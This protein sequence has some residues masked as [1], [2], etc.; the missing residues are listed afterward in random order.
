MVTFAP[1]LS[2]RY[3]RLCSIFTCHLQTKQVSSLVSF[4]GLNLPHSQPQP[5]HSQTPTCPFPAPNLPHSQP[6]T[7]LIPRSQP[8][9]FPDPNLPHSQTPTCLIP[10]LLPKFLLFA[11]QSI[12]TAKAIVVSQ[13]FSCISCRSLRY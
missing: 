13:C 10:R 5:A 4:P 12:Q 11:I 6:P 8:A 2:P 9:S 3:L 1:L 7:C